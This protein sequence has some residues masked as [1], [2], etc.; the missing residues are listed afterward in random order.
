MPCTSSGVVS[1]RTRIVLRPCSFQV[2]ASS[3]EKTI[4]PA[5]APGEALSPLHATATRSLGSMRAW[6]SWSSD[7][8]L[9]MPTARRLSMSPSSTRSRAIFTAASAVRFA[10]RVCSMKSFPR[11]TVNS[12]S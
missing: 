2:T 4:W 9:T 7:C 10:L 3:A 12:R 6:K 8:A 11:S 1:V 5:A